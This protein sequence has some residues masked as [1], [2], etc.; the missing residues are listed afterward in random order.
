MFEMYKSRKRKIT[1][2]QYGVLKEYYT[3][4]DKEVHIDYRLVREI[5]FSKNKE[6]VVRM[7]Q[8]NENDIYIVKKS[9]WNGIT[10][11]SSNKITKDECQKLISGDV[12]WMNNQERAI[13]YSLYLQMKYNKTAPKLVAEYMKETCMGIGSREKIIFTYGSSETKK[14]M[15]SFFDINAKMEAKGKS[16]YSEMQSEITAPSFLLQLT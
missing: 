10:Y 13:V 8:M 14:H 3:K 11:E 6:F 16:I 5:S 2:E 9:V 15:E 12:E 1:E 7:E 4:S